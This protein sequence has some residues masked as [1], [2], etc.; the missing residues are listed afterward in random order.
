MATVQTPAA[1]AAA[2]ALSPT[3]PT[4]QVASFDSEGKRCLSVADGTVGA[5]ITCAAPAAVQA[6]GLV[7]VMRAGADG[8][9][10]EVP[11]T[12]TL[13]ALAPANA[14]RAVLRRS[15]GTTRAV[16]VTN[17]F[18]AVRVAD[19]EAVLQWDTASNAARIP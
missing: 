5:G 15:D 9:G 18:V 13:Y 16:D 11:G 2:R 1:A 14:K 10:A 7:G 17:G 4:P 8:S 12:S 3:V 6:Q 19:D